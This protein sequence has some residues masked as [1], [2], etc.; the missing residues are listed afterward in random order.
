[1]AIRIGGME[2][3]VGMDD[4]NGCRPRRGVGGGLAIENG[5]YAWPVLEKQRHVTRSQRAK[6]GAGPRKT[7]KA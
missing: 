5:H 4:M 2:D 7:R 3:R 1:M 6:T